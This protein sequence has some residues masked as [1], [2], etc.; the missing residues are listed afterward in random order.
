MTMFLVIVA[1]AVL[2][3]WMLRRGGQSDS[4]ATGKKHKSKVSGAVQRALP[5]DDAVIGG[6]P[7]AGSFGGDPGPSAMYKDLREYLINGIDRIFD[8]NAPMPDEGSMPRTREQIDPQVLKTALEHLAGMDQFRAQQ[9]RLQK[10]LN[11]PAVQ[12]TDLSKSITS[13]PLMTAKVLRIANSSYFG[14]AQKI[15]S[16]S[17][18]LMILGMQN[19][20]SIM[21]REG[22]RDL[23]ETG[24]PQNRA[25]A[26]ALWRHSNLV[27][28]CTQHFYDLF[29]GLNRGTLFT[30]GMVHDIGKL[31]LMGAFSHLPRTAGLGDPYPMDLLIGGEDRLFGFNHAVIGGCALEHW[32]FSELMTRAVGNHH[33]PSFVEA[34]RAGLAPELLAYVLVLFLSDAVARL[35]AGWNEET[36]HLYP[37]RGSYFELVDRKKLLSKVTDAGFLNQMR[38][39]EM[40]SAAEHQR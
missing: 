18:A 6:S 32:N 4:A 33:T 25:A 17:H 20:K 22:M 15:D 40:I 10:L 13:D 39:V 3:V 2:A 16:I 8:E 1:V 12:M 37:L 11:D 9:V 26:A 19:I 34:D 5:K 38:A 28:I 14:V 23:F 35:F 30:L 27:A 36:V 7:A 24:A 21:Y 31:I 29:E